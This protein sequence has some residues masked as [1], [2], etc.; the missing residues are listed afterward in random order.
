MQ[1]KVIQNETTSDKSSS[2]STTVIVSIN[3]ETSSEDSVKTSMNTEENN[4][5]QL[6]VTTPTVSN[7]INTKGKVSTK[8]D[9]NEVAPK[10]RIPCFWQK[11]PSS[12]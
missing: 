6:E 4:N 10:F 7:I 9:N 5:E 1:K 2:V 12:E 11:W 8:N 3:E